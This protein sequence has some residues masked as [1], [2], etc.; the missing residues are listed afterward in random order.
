M[1]E[2][3]D[4]PLYRDRICGID[5]GKAGMVA[6]IRTAEKVLRDAFT[7]AVW[8]WPSGSADS[9]AAGRPGGP[10]CRPIRSCDGSRVLEVAVA[11]EEAAEESRQY[12]EAGDDRRAQPVGAGGRGGNHV[13]EDGCVQEPVTGM[14]DAAREL[15]E[16]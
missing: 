8:R 2:V 15:D 9:G 7:T 5:V 1:K 6:T 13:E 11:E 12:P 3:R 4:E 14:N 16:K 10:C